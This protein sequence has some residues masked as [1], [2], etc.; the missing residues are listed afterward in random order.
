MLQFVRFCLVGGAGLLINLLITHVGVVVFHLW[1]FYAFLVATLFAWTSI[2]IANAFI[3]FPEHSK[4]DYRNKYARFLFGYGAIFLIN[5]SL[6][7]ALTSLLGVP[8]LISI[9]FSALVTAGLTFL[10]S[11]YAVYA[12]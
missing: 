4:S 12:Q 1:Y 10:F 9:M 8:Y 2:F 6:V 7:F 5:A 11:K 3:T